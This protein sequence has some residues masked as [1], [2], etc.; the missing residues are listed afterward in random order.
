MNQGSWASFCISTY[1]RPTFLR[2]QLRSLLEQTYTNFEIIIS[3]NDPSASGREIALEFADPRIKYFHNGE[4]LGMIK[5]FNKSIER[6]TSMYV[7]MV[8]DDDPVE[9]IFLA[10]M[11]KLEER[12]PGHSL[13]AGFERKKSPGYIEI[14][15]S[16]DFIPEILDPG[17]TPWML[18][19]SA[20]LKREIAIEIG[21]IPDYGSPHLADHALIAMV[22]SIN[23]GVIINNK[24]SSLTL[25]ES[26][27]SKFNFEYYTLGCKGFYEILERF[28]NKYALNPRANFAIVKH[29]ESWLIGNV[30]NLKRYYSTKQ[31]NRPVLDHVEECAKEIL[32]FPFMKKAIFKYRIKEIVF[33]LKK[34]FG[35]L[36]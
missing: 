24:Y 19:S 18:W 1:R 3:D 30:F 11:R 10:E 25:H 35:L 9:K 8:T 26:N 34:K 17:K 7:V 32:S 12:Y 2:N 6:S 13:Y 16:K 5:S 20:I 33:I 23:G 28:C 29:L 31:F 21:M 14:I 15:D 4:N 36:K 27:F 22:G